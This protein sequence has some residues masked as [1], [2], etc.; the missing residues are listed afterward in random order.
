[1][2]P[3]S[4]RQFLRSAA[5]AVAA[6]GPGPRG[7]WAQGSVKVGTAVLGDYA[8]AGPIVVALERG[9]FKQEGIDVEYIPFRGGPDLAKAIIAG[10]ILL[11]ATGSTDI[12][13]FREAGMPTPKAT[14]SPST[15]RPTSSRSVTSR[16]RPSGSPGWAPPPGSSPACWPSSRGGTP[17][18]T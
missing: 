9:L 17:T 2:T 16:A 14:T 6:A 10:E 8:L 12:F 18:G 11:G 3:L 1:M 4:R 7:A 5:L 13:V 15:S